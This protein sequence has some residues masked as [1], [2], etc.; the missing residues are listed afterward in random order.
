M[1]DKEKAIEDLKMFYGYPPYHEG[2]NFVEGDGYFAAS[3]RT[4]YKV[5]SLDELEKW[6]GFEKYHQAWKKAITS[7]PK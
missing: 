7:F 2:S 4:K 1:I 6:V 5:K 3:I